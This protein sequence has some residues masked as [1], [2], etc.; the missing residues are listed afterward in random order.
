ML[1]NKKLSFCGAFMLIC[2]CMGLVS[3]VATNRDLGSSGDAF[4]QALTARQEA[5]RKA[6]GNPDDLT[7][8]ELFALKHNSGQQSVGETLMHMT[9]EPLRD[10][11]KVDAV[12]AYSMNVVNKLLHC[13]PC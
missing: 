11:A 2:C 9:K 12:V 6:G 5:Y 13:S 7:V 10:F 4:Q 1:Q 3:A 8:H